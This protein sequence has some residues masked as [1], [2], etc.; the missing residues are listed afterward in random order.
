MSATEQARDGSVITL[1]LR[2]RKDDVA[3]PSEFDLSAA[4]DLH[5][6][7]MLGFA[8]NVLHDRVLA[9]DCVQETFLRAWRAR[10]GFDASR[11]AVRTWLFAIERNVITDVQRSIGRMPSIASNYIDD[12]TADGRDAEADTVERMRVVEA[13]AVLSPEHR[14]VVIAIHLQGGSYAE[15]AASTGVAAATLRT[16]TYYALRI[17]RAHFDNQGDR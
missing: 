3:S 13:L 14:Q 1:N 12:E 16:R 2:R 15:L 17:L 9:E 10:G 4:F 11:G 6:S 8:V 5:A 7:A